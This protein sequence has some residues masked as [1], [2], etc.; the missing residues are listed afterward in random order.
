MFSLD[1]RKILVVGVANRAS[2]A[3]RCAGAFRA[4][5]V[6]LA[7]ARVSDR[8]VAFVRPPAWEPGWKS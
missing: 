7:L 4:Q 6:D 1:G 8:T 5:G 2:I 3:R